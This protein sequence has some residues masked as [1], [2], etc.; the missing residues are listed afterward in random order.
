M[1]SHDDALC[2]SVMSELQAVPSD[3]FLDEEFDTDYYFSRYALWSKSKSK[4][5]VLLLKS[6]HQ[7][8]TKT[9]SWYRLS[10]F[11]LEYIAYNRS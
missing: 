1:V 8:P 3:I 6:V 2:Q 9:Q 10:K 7:D 11:L 4:A 5:R